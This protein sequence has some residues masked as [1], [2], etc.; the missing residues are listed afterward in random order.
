MLGD[1][2]KLDL[3]N[4]DQARWINLTDSARGSVPTRRCLFGMASASHGG[5]GNDDG[6][7]IFVFGGL[8]STGNSEL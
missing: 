7:S 2:Y 5:H 4:P 3:W 1:M 8:D 6:V